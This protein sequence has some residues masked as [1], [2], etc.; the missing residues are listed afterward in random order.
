MQSTHAPR[1]PLFLAAFALVLVPGFALAPA[2]AAQTP[3]PVDDAA[4]PKLG[5]WTWETTPAHLRIAA[6]LREARRAGPSDGPLLQQ[7]IIGS[8][9]DSIAAQVDILLRGR[10]PETS[11]KD[12]PQ[13]LSDAQRE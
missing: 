4:P 1:F 11:P 13:V 7:R 5:P 12:G 6:A 2:A 9:K 10:V 8:G 3:A